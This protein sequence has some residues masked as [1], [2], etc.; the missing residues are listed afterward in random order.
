MVYVKSNATSN[1]TSSGSSNETLSEEELLSQEYLNFNVPD[2]AVIKNEKPL[3]FEEEAINAA[4]VLKMQQNQIP[5]EMQIQDMNNQGSIELKFNQRMKFD[6]SV[7]ELNQDA[8]F[9]DI[10][11]SGDADIVQEIIYNWTV[12]SYTEDSIKIQINYENPNYVS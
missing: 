1:S 8:I 11:T 12:D 4:I 7:L 5:I 6:A 10:F 3:L 9:I 2:G